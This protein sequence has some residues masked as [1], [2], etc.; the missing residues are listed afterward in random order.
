MSKPLPTVLRAKRDRSA[1]PSHKTRERERSRS[2]KAIERCADGKI[3]VDALTTFL[4]SR[5]PPPP[6]APNNP[7]GAKN[8]LMFT[9]VERKQ[10]T[11]EQF[12]LL[13]AFVTLNALAVERLATVPPGTAP[14]AHKALLWGRVCLAIARSAD[15]LCKQIF[16]DDDTHWDATLDRMDRSCMV[17]RT[18]LPMT[19]E[20]TVAEIDA[21]LASLAPPSVPDA[22]AKKR[23]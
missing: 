11:D 1:S 3:N 2:P 7:H 8:V 22:A 13:T 15:D 4:R 20:P 18:V 16:G 5:S 17:I 12:R 9:D 6:P 19:P 10:M 23:V 14:W 21:A